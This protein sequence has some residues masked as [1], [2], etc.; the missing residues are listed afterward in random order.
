[1]LKEL[2]KTV[3]K[4]LVNIPGWRTDR[5]IVVIESD[6][7]GSI[8][9]PSS[10][11]LSKLAKKGIRVQN[12]HYMQNDALAS[13]EDLKQLYSLLSSHEDSCG[14]NPVITANVIMTNP[15]FEKI[16][17]SGFTEYH[18]KT[19]VESLNEYPEHKNSFK[20]WKEG[21]NK[22]LFHPQFHGREHLQ[23]MRWM[24]FLNNSN[25]ETRKAFDIGV[26]GVST[27]VTTEDRK[28]LMASYDWDDVKSQDFVLQSVAEGLSLF[29]SVFKYKSLSS[30]APNYI[31]HHDIEKVL[32]ENGVRFIQGGRAQKMPIIGEDDFKI[33]RHFTGQKNRFGQKYLVRNCKFEPSSNPDV[34]WVNKCMN[35]IKRAFL[36]KKPAI[37]ESHRV[38]FIG[39]INAENRTR[40]LD[41]L[42]E[43]LT[44]IRKTWPTVEF[45][46]SDQLGKLIENNE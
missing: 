1:M 14:K 33:I 22:R 4:H 15:D 17:A 46:T 5:N 35:D 38:N 39:Y 36:W 23:V 9:M 7:W 28:S 24:N 10:D 8:R 11:S 18:Y 27:T 31:W 34:D 45:M 43:L 32:S 37:I 6:D 44:R 30:I 41:L 16:K 40:N 42:N 2:K 13:E 3:G 19:F 29:E 21:M 12:C 26:F 25:S 20:L